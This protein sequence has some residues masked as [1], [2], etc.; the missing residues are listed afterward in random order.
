MT[1]SPS[2]EITTVALQ[3]TPS[4]KCIGFPTFG[5]QSFFAGHNLSFS[6]KE[7]LQTLSSDR[8]GVNNKENR[9]ELLGGVFNVPAHETDIF[10]ISAMQRLRECLNEHFD[11]HSD[12]CVK[13]MAA[14]QFVIASCN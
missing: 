10:V 4:R 3:R 1:F 13:E 12:A 7:H 11:D 6:S 14:P 9:R 8:S 2:K 5:A